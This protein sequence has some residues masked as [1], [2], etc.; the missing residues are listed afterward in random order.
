MMGVLAAPKSMRGKWLGNSGRVF[1]S[2]ARL[3]LIPPI[4]FDAFPITGTLHYQTAHGRIV[5]QDLFLFV[6]ICPAGV[7]SH[8]LCLRFSP[9]P[10]N[11]CTSRRFYFF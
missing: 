7:L 9:P 6:G 1:G 4:D 5:D 3:H 8:D 10:S 11:P 2:N